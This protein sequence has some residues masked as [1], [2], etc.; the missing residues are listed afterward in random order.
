MCK[1]GILIFLL[2]LSTPCWAQD[3]TITGR[4]TDA[5]GALLPG[6]TLTLSSPQVMGTRTALTDETGGYRFGL[7]PPGIYSVKYELPGFKIL[8]RTGIQMSAGFVAT[9]NVSLEI[10]TVSETVTVEG[11]SPL[12]D[13][14]SASVATNFNPTAIAVIPNG[15]DIFSVLAVTP[16]VQVMVPDV[17]GSEVRQR[18]SFRVY[19]ST[20]QW[21]VI[22][23]AIVTSLLY[24][25]PD[26]YQEMRFA[27]ASKGAE[28]PVAGSYNTFVVKSGGNDFHGMIFADWE[29]LKLQSSNLTEEV[30]AQGAR[31]ANS[32]ARY[33][34]FHAD[35][36]G[37]IIRDKLWWFW[38]MR[39][40]KS[41]LNLIGFVNAQTGEP[42]IAKTTLQ[43]QTAKFSYQLLRNTSLSYTVQ[44]DRKYQPHVVTATD[45]A[46]I[47][48]DS[49]AIQDNPEWVQSIVMNSALNSRST[50]EVRFGEFGW[51][52]PRVSRVDAVNTRDLGTQI[53]RGGV[54]APFADRSH[55]KN[56]DVV[57]SINA[58]GARIGSHNL[59][60]GYG[61]LWEGA[62]YTRFSPKD[63]IS[64]I[65]QNS[66]PQFIETFDTPFTFENRSMHHSAFINDSWNFKRITFN[67]G[68]RFDAFQPSY[69]E[70][71]KTGA[72]PYQEQVKF[73]AFKFHWQNAFVPRLSTV[74]D[75]FGNGK[76]AIKFA[77][78]KYVYN[79]GSITNANSTLAGFVNPMSLTTKRYRWAGEPLTLP[80]V[81]GPTNTLISTTGG[82][83]RRLDPN[84]ELP[85]TIEYMGGLD[86]EIM[87]DMTARFTFVRKFERNRYQL[88]NTAIPIETA[89][90]TPVSFTDI[91]RD[92]RTGTSDDQVLT[93]FGRNPAFA[94]LRADLLTNDPANSASFT[95]Y[96]MEL[97]KRF[98]Q[99]WQMLSGFDIN[100]YKTWRFA[101][102]N[103]SDMQMD[104]TGRAQDPNLLRFNNGLNY[105]H[106]QY[107]AL[108]SYEL[109]FGI[110]TAATVRITKGEPYG[111]TVNTPA[112][113]LN[114]GTLNLRVEPI[115]SSFYPTVKIL[116]LRAAKSFTLG[117][118]WGKLEA[119]LD[120]FNV[121]NSSAVLAVNNQ[122]GFDN[123]RQR[124]T[125][126]LVQQTLN[127]R[128][129]RLG[130]RWTF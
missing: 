66:T 104:T 3:G 49:A 62:P 59:R 70:Q 68:L 60:I 17:G 112:A 14:Q 85:Y 11:D 61:A 101:A 97:V 82:V 33:V 89:Y 119:L 54:Q 42:E 9:L 12:I 34:A 37:P 86:Q 93:L 57:Y 71:E 38:G 96:N 81:P 23:G 114:Q 16:G 47:N 25:D 13:V 28:A 126:G 109:P 35:A 100:H 116:D 87:R 108:G 55:H 80:F 127:P 39:E 41:D 21:N 19:G 67:A 95:T 98:S 36:G 30:R 43:N 111:R 103:G 22:D 129:A 76:T 64:L 20:S 5:S 51:K 78:G 118:N 32:I 107:K 56:V 122:T 88:L 24:Q 77:F 45:A 91:G 46:F 58:A 120:V 65:Y 29:P 1:L 52:F 26:S 79:A 121:N 117:E 113:L 18:S 83:N 125:F 63:N 105:W 94:G 102:A 15:H 6:V 123:V 73:N 90:P 27:A 128:I 99:K 130:V 124:P 53:V 48:T 4:V 40:I 110:T 72:G 7:L 10:A 75:I 44:W 69:P 84:L 115:G 31:N 8:E 2:L 74:I 50:L 106:W 92:G